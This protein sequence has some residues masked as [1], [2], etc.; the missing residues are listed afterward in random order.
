MSVSEADIAFA[1][2]LF[3]GLAPLTTR[4]MMGGLCLYRDGTIFAILHS[5]GSIWLK[6]AGSFAG[7]MTAEGWTRWTYSRDGK[8]TTAMPYWRLPDAALD[9]S[10]MACDL[11]RS[12]L[13][14]L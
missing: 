14:E 3:D 1:L 9:D 11:A 10:G 12:A 8:K 6:G 13:A 5:D 2:E 4:K 7:R